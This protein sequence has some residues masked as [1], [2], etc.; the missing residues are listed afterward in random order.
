MAIKYFAA[1]GTKETQLRRPLAQSS[2]LPRF[3]TPWGTI[4]ST[5]GPAGMAQ[6]TQ[7][8]CAQQCTCS[9]M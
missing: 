3:G 1:S 2:P 4:G 6:R 9:S 7:S 8:A 5:L